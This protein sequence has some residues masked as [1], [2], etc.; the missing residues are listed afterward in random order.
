MQPALYVI[1]KDAVDAY[2][3]IYYQEKTSGKNT[4]PLNEGLL[5]TLTS[6][7]KTRLNFACYK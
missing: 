6:G 5:T 1:C 7:V 4:R 2:Y 3:L